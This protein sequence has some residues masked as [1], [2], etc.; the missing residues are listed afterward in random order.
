MNKYFFV[1]TI[2][3]PIIVSVVLVSCEK[4]NI[5]KFADNDS[6]WAKSETLSINPELKSDLKVDVAIIGGGYT[7]LSSA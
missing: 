6:Y 2:A 4:F 3:I 7:G 5:E 1:S